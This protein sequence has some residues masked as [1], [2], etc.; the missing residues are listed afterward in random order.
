MV[1]SSEQPWT[2]YDTSIG[3]IGKSYADPIF[4]QN[5]HL[6]S[7]TPLIT[8]YQIHVRY[9]KVGEEWSGWHWIQEDVLK[10]HHAYRFSTHGK[11]LYI[12]S[13]LERELI[14]SYKQEYHERTKS[15]SQQI[16]SDIHEDVANELILST[17]AGKHLQRYCVNAFSGE[18]DV[19]DNF[20]VKI[21]EV[22]PVEYTDY[23]S[24]NRD[25]GLRT[26]LNLTF[27]PISV[28]GKE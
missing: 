8:E 17:N 3:S 2:I 23:E 5:W 1:A 6:F 16:P 28:N 22:F 21:I 4:E 24:V 10:K 19:L 25:L 11:L 27:P 18:E 12:F 20:Q 14:N 15:D 26:V 7:P 9:Q 13:A